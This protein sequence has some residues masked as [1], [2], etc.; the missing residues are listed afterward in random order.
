MSEQPADAPDLRHIESWVFD[1]DNTLY[2]ARLNLFSQVDERMRRFIVEL[3]DVDE[4]EARRLQKGYFVQHGT[5]L[6]GLIEN[7]DIDPADFL[8]YVHDIDVSV[9]PP[10]PALA[11]ALDRL[12][13]RKLVFTNGSRRHAENVMERIGIA[14][15]FDGIFDIVD[16]RF[17][18]KKEIAPYRSFV[19]RHRVE[20]GRAAMFEDM[21]RN[22]IP[23]HA[24]G[25]TTVWVPGISA[26][27]HE[28][29]E[30]DHI[31]HITHD[32]TGFLE[33]VVAAR[34]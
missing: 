33:A 7:H 21:A 20:P 10:D 15:R 2:P 28:A 19:E 25:M 12:P 8:A 30:G 13:G 32:L 26:W 14:D 34:G 29:A 31:H 1:L 5:T 17:I 18:P 11:A 22:L 9:L 16:S 24:L 23:A 3:L 6:K 4:E 27:S